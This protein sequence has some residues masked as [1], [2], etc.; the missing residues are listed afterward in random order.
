MSWDKPDVS[1][2]FNPVSGA[3]IQNGMDAVS[4]ATPHFM[5]AVKSIPEKLT[6]FANFDPVTAQWLIGGF[7]GMMTLFAVS[8]IIQNSTMMN[9]NWV[10]GVI[11]PMLKIALP[12][13]VGFG[14]ADWTAHGFNDFGGAL[15][16]TTEG[17]D[18]TIRNAVIAP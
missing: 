7:A 18:K 2:V 16:R 11:S 5:N 17:L 9:K 3:Q 8:R 14:T 13:L 12:L 6:Q 15:K 4:N 10:G 1:E